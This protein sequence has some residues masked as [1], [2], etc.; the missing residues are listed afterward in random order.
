MNKILTYIFLTIALFTFGARDAYAEMN[1]ADASASLVVTSKPFDYRVYRLKNYLNSHN[2]PL[3]E[4]SEEFIQYADTYD[5][6]WRM[7]PA[8][9]GVE[10]TFGKRIPQNSYNAYGWANGEYRFT[11]WEDSI[12]H[13]S[14]TLKTKYIDKGAPSIAK[15]ARRYAPPST[16]WGTKVKF[17]MK[18]IDPLPLEFSLEG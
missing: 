13:V 3:A 15:I 6:D 2:S 16:T 5:I 11:S 1:T 7:V 9:S 17:F 8:I 10:S 18:K 4:Y 14:M 12:D